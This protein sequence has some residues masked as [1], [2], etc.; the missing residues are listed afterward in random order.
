MPAGVRITYGGQVKDQATVYNSIGVALDRGRDAHVPDPRGAVRLVLDPLAIMLSLPLS[1]IGVVLALLV[2][3]DTLNIMSLIGVILLMGIVAKNAI[4]LI[5][6]AKWSREERGLSTREALIEAGRIRLRPILMTTVALI[7]GMIPVALGVGEGADFRAPLG[8]AVI[9]GVITST[10]LT[11]LVIPTFYEILD[12]WRERL[13]ARFELGVAHRRHSARGSGRRHGAGGWRD[14]CSPPRR[15]AGGLS[16]TR[17]LACGD[18][19]SLRSAVGDLGLRLARRAEQHHR[20]VR[21]DHRRDRRPRAASPARLGR[22]QLRHRDVGRGHRAVLP[23]SL[24]QRV[25]P[26]AVAAAGA[27]ARPHAVGGAACAVAVVA[28]CPLCLRASH[29]RCR[30]R[31][32]SRMCRSPNTSQGSGISAFTWASL[33]TVLGW[34]FGRSATLVMRH[35]RRYEDVIG[36]ALAGLAGLLV[37]V[38]VGRTGQRTEDPAVR[39]FERELDVQSGEYPNVDEDEPRY[40]TQR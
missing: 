23:R 17:A 29:S 1:L 7:A 2:T 34:V 13:L 5:D 37:L 12:E 26:Q 32:A 35:V 6:F 20:G 28:G 25:D 11:L 40:G 30:S 3:R 16:V 36:L 15:G 38:Y 22:A 18:A 21:A 14:R 33:F 10:V 8:R 4:L 9:G 31:A 27:A 39:A 24:A 19:S